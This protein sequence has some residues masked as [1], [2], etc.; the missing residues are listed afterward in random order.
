MSEDL[1]DFLETL[2]Q[3]SAEAK[4]MGSANTSKLNRLHKKY[5]SIF[6]KMRAN[7]ALSELEELIYHP[8]KVIVN[9]VATYLL[10]QNEE[11][12]LK[13]LIELSKEDSFVG[14]GSRSNIKEWQAGNLNFDY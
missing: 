7:N 4:D 2:E 5:H 6:K 14:M 10:V 9:K 12:A 8:D 3:W 13:I 11:L 1:K